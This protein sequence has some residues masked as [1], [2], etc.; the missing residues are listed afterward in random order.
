MQLPLKNFKDRTDRKG[1]YAM[2][3]IC[4]H[5]HCREDGWP[6]IDQHGGGRVYIDFEELD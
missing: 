5:I 6:P 2:C 1:Y 4:R 3:T